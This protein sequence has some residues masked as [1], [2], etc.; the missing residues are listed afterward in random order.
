MD[1]FIIDLYTQVEFCAYGDLKEEIIRDRIVAGI[2]DARLAEKLQLDADLTLQ[3]AVALAR[4][5]P[6]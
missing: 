2:R 6:K 1:N 3:K 4:K 5:K